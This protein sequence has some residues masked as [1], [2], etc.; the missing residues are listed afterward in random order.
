MS[1]SDPITVSFERVAPLLKEAEE[2]GLDVGRLFADLG[3]PFSGRGAG[4]SGALSLADYFRLQNRL[5]ILFG[6]ETLH[7][8]S[9]QLLPGSTDFVLKN[10]ADCADL[11]EV[12]RVIA[13]SY[14]L[15]HGGNY[16]AVVKR[17]TT[18]EYTID[19][20][21]FPYALDQ[22]AEYLFFSIECILI[23]LHCLLMCAARRPDLPVA[24]LHI[25]R[26]SPGGDCAHLGYWDAPIR[27]GAD[28]YKLVFDRTDALQTIDA[29]APAAL[30]ANAVYQKLIETVVG[31]R[32]ERAG[33][34]T[35]ALVSDALVRGV[36]EQEAAAR[37]MGVSV[38]TLRRR[39]QAEGATFRDLRRRVLNDAAQRLLREGRTVGDVAE[40]LGFAE[41][42]SF[43][44]A[45]KEWNGCTPRAF[46]DDA[47]PA[48]GSAHRRRLEKR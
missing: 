38:A 24:S 29:A 30:T 40:A 10:A 5:A 13:Q 11:V 41:F 19:D 47:A 48:G 16:N 21:T 20:A 4:R 35:V 36:V 25:R 3:L 37:Q 31:R 23:F 17:R 9:R 42:R 34:T 43:S 1:E 33:R 12:M 32:P 45:F 28:R 7:L 8:S 6:D 22:N 27:F 15:L 14:N 44:R 26:P 2:A 39:L 46:L 18:V